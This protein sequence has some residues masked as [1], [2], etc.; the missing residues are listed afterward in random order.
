MKSIN[1]AVVGSNGYIGSRLVDYFQPK[2]KELIKIGQGKI[3]N[4]YNIDLEEPECFDYGIINNCDYVIFTA[5]ISS[6]DMC[7]KQYD[8]AYKINVT[9]TKYFIEEAL[10]R[11]CKVLF[12]S[13]DAVFGI[14]QIE[15]FNEKSITA[16]NTEY[17]IMKKEIEDSF[18]SNSLF[19]AIRL[20]YVVSPNDKFSSFVLKCKE[21]GELVEVFHPFYRN[22]ITLSDVIDSIEWLLCNWSH[23]ESS[24]LNICGSELVSRVR[25]VDEL[26]RISETKINYQVVQPPVDFFV[27]RPQVTEMESLYLQNVLKNWNEPFSQKIKKQFGN[28]IK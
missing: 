2:C 7:S 4:V 8:L 19:K 9:G 26:N 28:E 3:S 6:P 23:F 25:I 14:D 22:C 12:F 20:S 21:M 15:A 18:V 1:I 27:N 13:S 10:K 17:G 11:R 5:A 24:Y 16:A